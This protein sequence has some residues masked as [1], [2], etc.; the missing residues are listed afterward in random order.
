M[1]QTKAVHPA[2]AVR[3]WKTHDKTTPPA[4]D[5]IAVMKAKIK[6]RYAKGVP[7]IDAHG[8]IYLGDCTRV[9]PKASQIANVKLLLTSPPYFGVTNY[10]A[11]QWLRNWMLGGPS[12]PS[13]GKHA[14]MKRFGGREAYRSLLERAFTQA[15]KKLSKDSVILVR[16]DAREFALKTTMEIL[17]KIFPSKR[18]SSEVSI[19]DGRLSQTA[20]F[21]DKQ[22]KPGEVDLL[23]R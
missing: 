4:V 2:Y 9:L 10:Y 7:A 12:R 6:W 19:L 13:S 5:P 16:T 21:G 1:R 17:R 23:L 18:M 22:K 15:A 14:Y 20:L 3:W 8:K 11:D